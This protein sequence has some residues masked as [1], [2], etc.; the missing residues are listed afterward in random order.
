MPRRPSLSGSSPTH[1]K[2]VL[3]AASSLYCRARASSGEVTFRSRVPTPWRGQRN[4]RRIEKIILGQLSPSKSIGGL[5][6]YGLGGRLVHGDGCPGAVSLTSLAGSVSLRCALSLDGD[7][8]FCAWFSISL[9]CE[10]SPL[11]YG[12]SS[13][14]ASGS[15]GV[16][17]LY[18]LWMELARPSLSCAL[19]DVWRGEWPFTKCSA[20]HDRGFE[21]VEFMTVAVP[22][23]KP[24][25]LPHARYS[26]A[27]KLGLGLNPC[28]LCHQRRRKS[29]K[30]CENTSKRYVCSCSSSPK[31]WM[32]SAC[33]HT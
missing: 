25:P 3:T 14:K 8:V 2:I 11:R 21:G 28:L 10:S 5:R 1:S 17:L 12:S 20:C 16:F 18:V 24:K 13:P 23:H 33:C 19:I 22:S 6:V 7:N 27:I 4:F 31:Q 32:A 29:E 30:C 26:K 15:I 9:R